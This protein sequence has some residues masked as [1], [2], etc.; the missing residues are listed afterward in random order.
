MSELFTINFYLFLAYGSIFVG[1]RILYIIV[2]RRQWRAYHWLRGH[3]HVWVPL[4]LV[5]PW[6]P[7]VR[8]EIQT[9]IWGDELITATR[10]TMKRIDFPFDFPITDTEMVYFKVLCIYPHTATVYMVTYLPPSKRIKIS[11]TGDVYIRD[12]G[13]SGYVIKMRRVEDKWVCQK[14][15]SYWSQLTGKDTRLFPPY[16]ADD[17][18]PLRQ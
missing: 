2:K 12:H 4:L 17:G 7:F 6:L 13:Y 11:S 10:A 15:M 18:F 3:W 5:L 14:W 8:V 16:P 9:K 1:V